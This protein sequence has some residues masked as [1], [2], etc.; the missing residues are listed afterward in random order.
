M[1]YYDDSV[2]SNPNAPTLVNTSPGNLTAT[3]AGYIG[4]GDP[5]GDFFSLGNVLA[6]TQINLNLTQPATSLLGGVLNV[7]NSAGTNLT[8]N[9]TAGN[10]LQLHGAR[11]RRRHVLRRG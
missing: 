6:G 1:T 9:L 10:T 8:N 3:L 2:S 5:N 4:Q 11:G 7:Y